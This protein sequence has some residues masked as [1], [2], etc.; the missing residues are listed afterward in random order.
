MLLLL[1]LVFQA[2]RF[3]TAI[4]LV[5]VLKRRITGLVGGRLLA[6]LQLMSV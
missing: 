4:G 3:F 6:T 1:V 2:P 5:A